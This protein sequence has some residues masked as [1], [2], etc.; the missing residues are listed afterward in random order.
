VCRPCN[1][2]WV[3]SATT[4]YLAA[5]MQMRSHLRARETETYIGD[6]TKSVVDRGEMGGSDAGDIGRSEGGE[7]CRTEGEDFSLFSSQVFMFLAKG[8]YQPLRNRRRRRADEKGHAG[9]YPS[10]QSIKKERWHGYQCMQGLYA[11]HETLFESYAAQL[12]A[13]RILLR[14]SSWLVC[15]SK[16][17]YT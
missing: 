6:L 8:G 16:M 4:C 14:H 3:V 13:L 17:L 9:M 5:C 12:D 10:S 15:S 2:E 11:P 1:Y 7:G